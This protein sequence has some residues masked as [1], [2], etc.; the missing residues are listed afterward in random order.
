MAIGGVILCGG[1]GRRMGAD[2]ARLRFGPELLLQRVVRLVAASAGPV[3][4]VAAADQDLPPLPADVLVVRDPVPDLGPLPGL[5][6]GCRALPSATSLA[7]ATSTDAP[8]LLPRP[9]GR[10]AGRR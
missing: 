1:R 4:V 9:L 8:F 3:V 6:A 2:K 5:A 7:Y 10:I